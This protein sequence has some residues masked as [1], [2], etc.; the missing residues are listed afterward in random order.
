MDRH[1]VR[2]VFEHRILPQWFYED[3]EQF[4]GLLLHDKNVL[5]RVINN[6]FEKEE[7]SNPYTEDDFGVIASKVTEDVLMIKITFPAPEEEPLCYCSYLFFDHDFEKINYFCIEKGNEY[8]ENYP[9]VCSWD[10]DGHSNYGNCTFEEHNDFLRCADLYMKNT[11]GIE[12]H[13]GGKE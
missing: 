8:G 5:F 9:F 12:N 3:K 1:G 7:V 6:I 11:Y 10:E 13:N 4:V 2:Y